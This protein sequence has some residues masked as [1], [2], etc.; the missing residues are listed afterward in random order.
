MAVRQLLAVGRGLLL[1][2][3]TTHVGC[4]GTASVTYRGSVMA[5]DTARH[6]FAKDSLLDAPPLEGARVRMFH[7][8]HDR[9]TCTD[10]D[11]V[12]NGNSV[13]DGRGRYKLYLPFG[14][15]LISPENAFLLCVSHADYD[16][17]EYRAVFEKVPNAETNGTQYLNFYLRKKSPS[18][19]C[20]EG[21][22]C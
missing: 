7:I 2:A 18:P 20:G 11:D 8:T 9:R 17:Y 3:L 15:T 16:P 4:A 6:E 22:K 12:S 10:G 14:G 1:L 5:S 19:P 13:T 21:G